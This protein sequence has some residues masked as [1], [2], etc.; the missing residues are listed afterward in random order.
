MSRVPKITGIDPFFKSPRTPGPFGHNDAADPT[1]SKGLFG[2]TPG[3]LGINDHADPT[4]FAGPI[5]TK[6]R[7]TNANAPQNYFG[8]G[9]AD[10]KTDGN[11][12]T[13]IRRIPLIPQKSDMSCWVAAGTMV[14]GYVPAVTSEMWIGKRTKIKSE[15]GGLNLLKETNLRKFMMLN[16]LILYPM[17]KWTIEGIAERLRTRSALFYAPGIHAMVIAGIKV[18]KSNPDASKLIL[19]D[20]QPV[21]KGQKV[22]ESWGSWKNAVK[23]MINVVGDDPKQVAAL[24]K[25]GYLGPGQW[26]LHR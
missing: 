10:V 21:G 2:D 14:L 1:S 24:K 7:E 9:G 8:P 15:I 3:C 6:I 5:V 4:Y 23:S 16:G 17:T 13:I 20:P 12:T 11:I 26:L 18:Y 19:Y 22:E 25:R